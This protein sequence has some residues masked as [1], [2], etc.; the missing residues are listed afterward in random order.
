MPQIGFMDL[1]NRAT[2][3]H[4]LRDLRF[5]RRR[6]CIASIGSRVSTPKPLCRHGEPDQANAAEA[7]PDSGWAIRPDCQQHGANQQA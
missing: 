6:L 7:S 3:G 5:E 1:Q 2:C 4:T